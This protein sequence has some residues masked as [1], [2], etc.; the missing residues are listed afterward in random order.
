M[1]EVVGVVVTGHGVASGRAG[2]PRF[3]TGT[4]ELQIPFFA[5]RGVDLSGFWPGTINVSTA[6][7]VVEMVRPTHTLVDV[8]WHPDVDA[9]TF[10]FLDVRVRIGSGPWCDGLVYRPHPETK[11]E[12]HQPPHVLELLAP[13]RSG[14][15]E[16]A[17][18][19]LAF[20]EG[21]VSLSE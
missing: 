14:V 16:G 11:P 5:A 19:S 12:H 15:S 2:D 6:P 10:S 8:T 18:V 13:R 4:I 7:T 3:P 9:E 17:L 1:I 20:G 21:D